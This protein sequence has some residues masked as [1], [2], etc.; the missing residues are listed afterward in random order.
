MIVS[1]LPRRLVLGL[2]LTFGCLLAFG[3]LIA[4]AFAG[5][6]A[7][8]RLVLELFTSQGC[9]SCP[10]ADALMAKLARQ[11][12]VLVLSFPVDYWDYLGWHDTLASAAFSARQRS[13]CKARGDRQVYTPQVVI[14]G[15]THAIGSEQAA[16]ETAAAQGE[17]PE[18]LSVP[19]SLEARADMLTISVGAAGKGPRSG[20]L[21]LFPIE[22][23][24]QVAIGRGENS[25]KTLTYTN[26][27]RAI[28]RI[29]DW[30]GTARSYEVPAAR[31]KAGTADAYVVLLQAGSDKSPGMVL[32]ATQGPSLPY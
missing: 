10:P 8:P 20:A 7:K 16:I 26:V 19:V 32:G 18:A 4:P 30:D 28:I 5:E 22:R 27:V 21:W 9:S 3:C 29:G 17:A 23:Q 13:Y 31:L 12:G 11:P 25:G 15:V 2:A 1:L 6:A 24:H 14:N